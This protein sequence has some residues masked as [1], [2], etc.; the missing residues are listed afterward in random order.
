MNKK[1]IATA[2]FSTFTVSTASNT[3]A[4]NK[5]IEFINNHTELSI[6]VGSS[7][8]ILLPALVFLLAINKLKRSEDQK[9]DWF[10]M[11]GGTQK[12]IDNYKNLLKN[13][14]KTVNSLTGNAKKAFDEDVKFIDKDVTRTGTGLDEKYYGALERILKIYALHNN[15][16]KNKENGQYRQGYNIWCALITKKFAN[17][18][19]SINED[20][21]AKIYFVYKGII[22]ALLPIMDDNGIPKILEDKIYSDLYKNFLER[23]KISDESLPVLM[24]NDN[25]RNNLLCPNLFEFFGKFLT[26]DDRL[27]LMD[28][29]IS[30]A[31][32]NG[33][34]DPEVVL[35]TM[36]DKLYEIILKYNDDFLTYCENQKVVSD[37]SDNKF[38]AM[39][40]FSEFR[41]YMAKK[42]MPC[43]KA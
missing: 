31:T 28:K 6:F 30:N 21:E 25:C 17:N 27:L 42:S 20:T 36:V 18:S 3:S 34:F 41:Q 38:D 24:K 15:P 9:S 4:K 13:Y 16:C 43:P 8:V 1:I 37:D 32:K 10:K 39:L 33:N 23:N 19:D 26:V 11:L 35:Q 40:Y 7:T 12:D 14:D 29:V 5:I 22:K 2:L